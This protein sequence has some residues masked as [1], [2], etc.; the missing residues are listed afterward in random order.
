M[1]IAHRQARWFLSRTILTI[2]VFGIA[3]NVIVAWCC[4]ILI[5]VEEKA[6]PAVAITISD[7]EAWRVVRW[8][9]AGA[10]SVLSQRYFAGG[11]SSSKTKPSALV[12]AWVDFDRPTP[13]WE[14]RTIPYES[15]MADARGWPLPSLWSLTE[16]AR[17]LHNKSVHGGIVLLDCIFPLRPRW[18]GF[19]VDS[20]LYAFAAALPF[21]PFTVR[22]F[23]RLWQYR[24]VKCGYP[25]G[26]SRRCTECG[27]ILD[28]Q[29]TAQ[30][31]A[32]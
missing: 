24:C 16:K 7:R 9:C 26:S 3:I 15:R 32:A 5:D 8:T 2:T 11:D 13:E 21:A 28:R 1:P 17:S 18:P 27:H 23:R 10:D 22:R 31:A 19:L 25:I 12:P 29:T 30:P 4:A 6:A 14:A 20:A